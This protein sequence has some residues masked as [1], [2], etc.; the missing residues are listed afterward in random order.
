MMNIDNRSYGGKLFRP[1]PEIFQR[2]DGLLVIAIPWGSKESAKNFIEIINEHVNIH[3]GDRDITSPFGV[4][5]SLSPL[6]NQLRTALLIA[7]NRIYSGENQSEYQSGIEVLIIC[8]EGEDLCLGQ[9]GGPNVFMDRKNL[10]LINLVSSWDLSTEMCSGT[11]L[12]SPLPKNLV[13]IDSSVQVNMKSIRTFDGDQ[14]ILLSRSYIP[15][16]FYTLP[17]ERRN[18]EDISRSLSQS[19]SVCPFWLGVVT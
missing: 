17:R 9:I 10:N 4:L 19:D 8:R 11:Q 5:T 18:L 6:A 12:L 1:T 16:A 15:N 13:G 7:N 3:E 2:E 14:L